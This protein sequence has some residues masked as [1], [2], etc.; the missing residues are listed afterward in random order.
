MALLIGTVALCALKAHGEEP[1]ADLKFNEALKAAQIGKKIVMIDFFT[2]WCGPCKRLDE[3]TWK[4][5]K[6]QQFLSEK[7]ISLKIDAEKEVE[8]AKRYNVRAYPTIVFVRPDGSLMDFIVGY[9]EPK[10]FMQEASAAMVSQD[11]LARIKAK[12]AGKENDPMARSEY[13]SDLAQLGKHQ[14]ALDEYLWCFDHG[15]DHVPAYYGVRVSFLLVS[16]AELGKDYPPALEALKQRR[17]AAKHA[18]LTGTASF[19]QTHDFAA[20]C[21]R[22]GSNDLI[23][24]VFDR[25]KEKGQSTKLLEQFIMEPLYGAK[26]YKDM[27]E[28]VG[29]ATLVVERSR[30]EA[31]TMQESTK[32]LPDE[33]RRDVLRVREEYR[34]KS[35]LRIYEALLAS[36]RPDDA[37]LIEKE[38]ISINGSPQTFQAMAEHARRAG[39]TQVAERLEQAAK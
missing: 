11:V 1:F 19:N 23:L 14:E 37:A 32:G 3:T 12:V 29:P 7:T 22:L 36:S 21:E 5:E 27:L 17:D 9:R 33:Q 15:L 20:L 30:N 10:T 16:I 2:T 18:V 24:A 31:Q 38:I 35:L 13:A 34:V 6:V 25:L 39:A 26:R 8:L 4:D 28:I